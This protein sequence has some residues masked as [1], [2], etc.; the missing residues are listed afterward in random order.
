MLKLVVFFLCSRFEGALCSRMEGGKSPLFHVQ[1]FCF[2]A[3]FLCTQEC[4][5]GC[6]CVCA[7]SVVNLDFKTFSYVLKLI[8][9]MI[10]AKNSR[11]FLAFRISRFTETCEP[12][13][14]S[15]THI[16]FHIFPCTPFY[17]W[18]THTFTCH[19]TSHREET[20]GTR[21]GKKVNGK[22]FSNNI[23]HLIFPFSVH[24]ATVTYDTICSLMIFV[25]TQFSNRF[26][27]PI[28]VQMY[29]WMSEC[30]WY[31][32]LNWFSA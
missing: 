19:N 18:H 23:K 12:R 22:T 1:Q 20:W 32:R 14:F 28:H 10:N 27:I 9:L 26:T 3:M 25:C 31:L 24:T 11:F 7:V 29:E 2:V 13:S 8:C 6:L 16:Y 15:Y 17:I 4:V 5:G 30:G 21:E